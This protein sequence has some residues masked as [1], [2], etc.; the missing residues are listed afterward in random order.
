[1]LTAMQL[2]VPRGE[3]PQA[4]FF[5]RCAVANSLSDGGMGNDEPYFPAAL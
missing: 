5:L 4:P 3:C 2:W 1:M